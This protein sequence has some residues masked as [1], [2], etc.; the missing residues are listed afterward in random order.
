MADAT[1]HRYNGVAFGSTVNTAQT[2]FTGQGVLHYITVNQTTATTIA[3]ADSAGV[4]KGT[5]KTSVAEG[6]YRYDMSMN[7][8]VITP[9]AHLGNITVV[10]TAG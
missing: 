6:T 4:N 2:I 10:F 5:L 8:C 1:K 9:G 3:I 7:G